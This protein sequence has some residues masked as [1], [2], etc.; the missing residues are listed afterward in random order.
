MPKPRNAWLAS[1]LT[2]LSAG[3][4]HLYAGRPW[5]AV[6]WALGLQALIV[7]LPFVVL[8]PG[9]GPWA[10]VLLWLLP[11]AV[12]A[13]LIHAWRVAR[14]APVP[15]TALPTNRWYVYL[16]FAGVN[17]GLSQLA[18]QPFLR[19][20][21]HGFRMPS[22][23][24]KPSLLIGDYIY[25]RLEKPPDIP[26]P[27]GAL[28]VFESTEEPGLQVLKRVVGVPGDTISMIET[29]LFRNGHKVP[30]PYAQ[31]DN[32]Q[33]RESP[34]YRGKMRAWQVKAAAGFDTA[35]YNPDL[36]DWG[37]LVVPPDS[38][39]VLGDNREASYDSRYYGWVPRD[40]LLGYPSIV[41]Y[42]YDALSPRLLPALTAIRWERL[43]LR[44]A[45]Q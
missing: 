15:F 33:K 14:K 23:S 19:S 22:G 12:V 32:R 11:L 31:H 16:T 36:S 7:L 3:L 34:E 40:H 38:L 35:T 28:V 27:A 44:F 1:L 4:G 37:P 25:A 24:M 41:Y 10:V 17:L 26:T 21:L 20:H 6:G 13:P 8:A 45:Q 18:T 42:S 30:E 29:E 5:Q 39:F 43:G 9:T 2:F